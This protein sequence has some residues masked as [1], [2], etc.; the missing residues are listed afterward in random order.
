ML[1]P[2][3]VKMI[4]DSNFTEIVKILPHKKLSED[5]DEITGEK[6]E[7]IDCDLV[8]YEIAYKWMTE[9]I[10]PA[11]MIE[12]PKSVVGLY[13]EFR[14]ICKNKAKTD[15]LDITEISLSQ[16]D[17]RDQIDWLSKDMIKRH[18]RLLVNYEYLYLTN[19]YGRGQRNSYRLASDEP[20]DH[21][22]ISR[23][24]TPAEVEK[25]LKQKNS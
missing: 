21:V 10:L 11:T 19:S 15:H 14:S 4:L 2:K 8:D 3:I 20:M 17:L 23:I 5:I 22:D 13:N 12:F 25:L 9:S 6:I 7:Y 18:L 1:N 24:P 16:K